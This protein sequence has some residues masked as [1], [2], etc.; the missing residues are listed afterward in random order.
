MRRLFGIVVALG[1]AMG[2]AV[3]LSGPAAAAIVANP[4]YV[5][6]K[7]VGS[8]LNVWFNG[9][10]VYAGL[11]VT[12]RPLCDY[13]FAIH[14]N[15][16]LQNDIGLSKRMLTFDTTS[17]IHGISLTIRRVGSSVKWVIFQIRPD[18]VASARAQRVLSSYLLIA[19]D[20]VRPR[21]VG[22][23]TGLVYAKV[24]SPS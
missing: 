3:G 23:A 13:R 20:S 9:R 11:G 18:L 14:A 19:R 12:C 8:G 10:R 16:F 6:L 7:R 5:L 2:G 15:R 21:V 1:L 22:Q 17:R 24:A 4:D